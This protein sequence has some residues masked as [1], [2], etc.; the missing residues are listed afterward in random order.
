M[1]KGNILY[2]LLII[3]NK[4]I[5]TSVVIGYIIFN[6]VYFRNNC[7][8]EQNIFWC[9]EG[10]MIS[11]RSILFD[12]PLILLEYLKWILNALFLDFGVFGMNDQ[13][14]VFF[15]ALEALLLSFSMIIFTVLIGLVVSIILINLNKYSFIRKNIIDPILSLSFIHLAIY[16][17]YFKF[18]LTDSSLISMFFLCFITAIGSGV[19]FDFYTLLNNEHNFIM[20]K[21]YVTFARN[22]GFSSYRFASKELIMSMIYISTSR[23]PIIFG[24]MIIIEILSQGNYKGIGFSIWLNIFGDPN[25]SA[26][27]GSIFLS[28]IVFT[29]I[30]Y[31]TEFIKQ[32]ILGNE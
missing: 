24:S 10:S 8:M 6:I 11:D 16:A 21:D 13:T 27:F 29:F 3:L 15:Y 7:I 32:T 28:I 25:Y 19:L 23:V 12:Q 18:F 5:I 22:S 1:N 31:L 30:Y 17:I 4:S 9:Q 20:S 14:D 2:N 26:F